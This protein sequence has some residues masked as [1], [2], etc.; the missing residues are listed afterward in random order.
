MLTSVTSPIY[1]KREARTTYLSLLPGLEFIVLRETDCKTGEV[2][3]TT[4]LQ[5][6][7]YR[8]DAARCSLQLANPKEPGWTGNLI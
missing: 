4:C 2:P 7:T 8:V 6:N 3:G 5:T 1:N